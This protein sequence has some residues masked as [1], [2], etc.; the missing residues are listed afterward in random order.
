MFERVWTVRFSD[1]DPFGIAFYPD[2]VHAVHETADMF[3]QEVG[4]P[5]WELSADHGI[6]LPIVEIDLSFSQ[7]LRAGDEVHITLTPDLGRRSVRFDY[8]GECDGEEA[9]AGFEQRAC[10]PVGG[11]GAI[12][13]PDDLRAAMAEHA[14]D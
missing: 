2:I 14:D 11:D 8:V 1:T 10:V 13:I 7:P 12:E 9:F 4:F 3:M 6:G 5:L